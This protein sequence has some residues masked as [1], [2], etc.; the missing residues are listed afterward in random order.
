MS[1]AVGET[2]SLLVMSRVAGERE[3]PE[4][5]P[6]R[7]TPVEGRVPA[8][9]AGGATTAQAARELGLTGDG[10]AYHPRRPSARR[11]AANRTELVARAY[12]LGV[13]KPGVRPPAPAE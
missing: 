13:L 6:A 7:V 10:L 2:P 4:A 8:L 9:P 5:E 12:A 3:A 11:D 1:E